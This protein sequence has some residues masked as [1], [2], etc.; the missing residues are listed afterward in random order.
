[1]RDTGGFSVSDGHD[2]T[3]RDE[4]ILVVGDIEDNRQLLIRRLRREGFEDIVTALLECIVWLLR[5]YGRQLAGHTEAEAAAASAAVP[6]VASLGRQPINGDTSS[7][8]PRPARIRKWWAWQGLNL[9]PLP[10]QGSALPLS[11]TPA[12]RRI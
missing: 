5:R 6:D 10:C 8:T 12:R 2:N 9:R 4:R 1:M 7:R 11:Y 3:R